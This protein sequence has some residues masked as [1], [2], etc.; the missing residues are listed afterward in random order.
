MQDHRT[1]TDKELRVLTDD[2]LDAVSGGIYFSKIVGIGGNGGLAI[3]INAGNI[4]FGG[5][6]WNTAIA[7]ANGGSGISLRT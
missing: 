5:T 2:E 6:Q 7:N 3:A 4:N 1:S